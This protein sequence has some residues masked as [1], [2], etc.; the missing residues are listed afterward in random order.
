MKKYN[1]ISSTNNDYYKINKEDY[2]EI[3]NNEKYY[4]NIS[5]IEKF[6]SIN[7]KKKILYHLFGSNIKHHRN[8]FALT[9]SNNEFTIERG[10]S[11]N[12]KSNFNLS[13]KKDIINPSLTNDNQNKINLYNYYKTNF[14]NINILKKTTTITT[15]F[16]SYRIANKL[17]EES[18]YSSR[19][20]QTLNDDDDKINYFDSEEQKKINNNKS[21]LN[22]NETIINEKKDIDNKDNNLKK[23]KSNKSVI[24]KNLSEQKK[25]KFSKNTKNFNQERRNTIFHSQKRGKTIKNN[26]GY[27]DIELLRKLIQE[28]YSKLEI[29]NGEYDNNLLLYAGYG[30]LIKP[31]HSSLYNGTFRYGK[32]EGI[33]IF[34]RE[35]SQIHFK[36]YMGEFTKNDFDGFGLS[37]EF[38]DKTYSTHAIY[39]SIETDSGKY[40][41]STE[42]AKVGVQIVKKYSID[43]SK[44]HKNSIKLLP[45]A[46]YSVSEVIDNGDGTERLINTKTGVSGDDGKF[47]IG[48]LFVN[49]TY[50]IN[51]IR[52]PENYELNREPIRIYATVNEQN[53]VVITVISG[54]VRDEIVVDQGTSTKAYI[55]IEDEVLAK[56]H[57]NKIDQDTNLPLKNIKF[58]IT[59]DN[60][61]LGKIFTTDNNGDINISN[62][63][64]GSEYTLEETK[65]TGYFP[66]DQITFTINNN[67]G[68]YTVD[69][70]SGNVD[71]SSISVDENSIPTVNFN[72][73]NQ[74]MPTYTLNLYKI[75]NTTSVDLS[76]NENPNAET[77]VYIKGARFELYQGDKK[78][79]EYETDDN[80]LISIP[81]LYAYTD[82]VTVDTTY[83]L[84]EIKTPTGYSKVKDIVFKVNSENGVLDFVEYLSYGQTAKDYTIS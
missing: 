42:P 51:E 30:T 22:N 70:T 58:K 15:G 16:N 34:Y 29:Y 23:K 33:G 84:K 17:T 52:S 18:N 39:F 12:S 21:I 44:Y 3:I 79:G 83:T 19:N 82:G 2:D 66:L 38:N 75:K 77:K 25:I 40:K 59:G 60:Y 46:T 27:N 81:D 78:I 1:F 53:N 11:N 76:Q 65:A 41:T 32:K 55:N 64:I 57:I 5:D 28:N 63:I 74:K 26:S 9:Q 45:G 35:Y 14:N 20:I 61:S 24:G 43:F 67:S 48:D 10:K 8:L 71:S 4:I 36:Y 49:R 37:I 47:E 68:N 7:K 50:V 62:L 13:F 56:L 73:S 80:G 31:N 54:D 6:K 69:I 72:I